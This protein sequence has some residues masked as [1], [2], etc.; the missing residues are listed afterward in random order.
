MKNNHLI[1]AVTRIFFYTAVIL[2][3]L[4]PSCKSDELKDQ[5]MVLTQQ[6]VLLA[7]EK[8]SLFKI[9]D[10]KKVEYDTLTA[11]YN[12]LSEDNKALLQKIKSLQAGYNARGGQI[13]KAEA[14]KADHYLL[15]ELRCRP[16][17]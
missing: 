12:S 6:Q 11:N 17:Q 10:A 4:L 7:N 15:Q 13:K 9:I 16:V 3:L 2:G 1:T 14:E 5:I 8:D